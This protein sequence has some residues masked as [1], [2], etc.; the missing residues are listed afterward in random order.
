[1]NI[2]TKILAVTYGGGHANI[3]IPVLQELNKRGIPTRF[4]A[5]TSAG[6]QA[7]R[8]GLEYKSYRDYSHL[9]DSHRAALLGSPLAK[10]MHNPSLGIPFEESVNYLGINL[11]E[12]IDSLGEDLAREALRLA[13]RNSFL[14]VEFLKRIIAEE[15]C[16]HVLTTNSPRSEKASLVAARELDLKSFRLDDLYGVPTLYDSLVHKMGLDMYQRTTGRYKI[17]PT[18]SCFLCDFARDHFISQ[19]DK[20]DVVGV[21]KANSTVTGQP[22]FDAIDKIIREVPEESLFPDRQHLP[23][24]TWAHEN[25]HRDETE[26]VAILEQCFQSKG[27]A[28]N[29][30]IKLRPGIERRQIQNILNRFDPSLGNLKLIHDEMNPNVLI[31]NSTVVI[32][33]V[34]TMLTQAA[35]MG[36][37]VVILDPLQLRAHEPLAQTGL[38]RLVRN[39]DELFE[40]INALSQAG[41]QMFDD[42]VAGCRSMHFQKQGTKNVCDLIE[43]Y[44]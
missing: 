2:K 36:R 22:A 13:G 10:E 5:L 18:Q 28:F 41:T 8:T 20:W 29:F 24:I 1:M 11:M 3:V 39:S 14:P 27:I 21:D 34:S 31:W 9:V 12:N 35:Y 44:L 40:A 42:F 4:L 43:R 33:Q 16:T 25:G 6:P 19:Q 23:T 26:V 15:R 30:V 38:A 37:P 7:R 17:T 32:G